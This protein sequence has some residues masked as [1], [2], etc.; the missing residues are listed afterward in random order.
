MSSIQGDLRRPEEAAAVM[1]Q[2][3]AALGT[4]EVCVANSGGWD[5][6]DLPV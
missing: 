6:E 4:V 3:V 1:D 5:A 2:A